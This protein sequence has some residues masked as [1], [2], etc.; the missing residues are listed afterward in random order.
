MRGEC[1]VLSAGA[2]L[3]TYLPAACTSPTPRLRVRRAG[4]PRGAVIVTINGGQ[5]GHLRDFEAGIAQARWT[6][7]A[8][9][10]APHHR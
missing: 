6:A 10:C 3:Q 1:H 4:I 8:L 5:D 7:S 9:R 2:A